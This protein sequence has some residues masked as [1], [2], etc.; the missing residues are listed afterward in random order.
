M[1]ITHYDDL[2]ETYREQVR[3]FAREKVAPFAAKVDEEERPPLDAYEASLE[4]GLPGLPFSEQFGGQEGDVIS[5]VITVEEL[6]RVCASTATTVSTC[7][8]MMLV[9]RFG[10]EEQK[11]TI[12]PPVVQGKHRSAWGLTEPKGGS[13]L[14]GV[15][16][17]AKQTAQG[18]LLNGTKRFITN[19]GWADWYLIFARTEADN[20]GIF[21]VNKEDPG[22]SFGAP[23]RKMGL[24]GSP[25]S[26]VILE[27]CLI[28][29]DR[30]VG[31]PAKGG[32]YIKAGLLASRLKYAAH[33]LGV[34]QGALDEAVAYTQNREQFGRPV[35]DFQMIKGMIADMAMKVEAGRG[36]L[37]HAATLVVNNDPRAK[38]Y[39]S[40]AKVMCTDAAMSVATDAVQLHGGYGYLKDYPV[41]RMLRDAKITQIWEGTNQIQR[42]MIAKEVYKG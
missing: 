12:I 13:D 29:L 35:A 10:S 14:M 11:R 39:A 16:S 36:L 30:V 23:E 9:Q 27:D 3:R 34:A 33:G 28:P 21:L 5:Q 32:E 40:M 42:L 31:D 22:V 37:M 7:W 18:W 15:V 25:T 4:L 17:S 6:A 20:F 2:Y 26:D 1:E 19:G 38:K 8:I 41:E 24:R